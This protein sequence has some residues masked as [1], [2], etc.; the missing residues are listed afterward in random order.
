MAERMQIVFGSDSDEKKVLPGILKFTKE[1]PGLEVR[2][3]YASADNTPAKVENV[4][5]DIQKINPT[6][7]ISGAGMSN[8]LTGVIKSKAAYYD[9]VIG[10]PITDSKTNGLSSL[11]S[12]GEKPPGNPVLMVGLGNTYAALNIGYRFEKGLEESNIVVLEKH[13]A[14]SQIESP[15][16]KLNLSLDDLGLDYSVKCMKDIEPDDVVLSVFPVNNTKPISGVDE[17]LKQGKGVQVGIPSIN[18]FAQYWGYTHCLDNEGATGIVGFSAYK[19]AAYLGAILTQNK[20]ALEKIREAKDEKKKK[21]TKNPGLL[22]VN[23][24]AKPYEGGY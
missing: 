8:V 11:L 7:H 9:L 18:D 2:V 3:H 15:I 1:N 24:E 21:L 12:T 6:L 5:R 16:E 20:D 4:L 23:G 13:L 14:K 19:N 22:V 10:V 17:I